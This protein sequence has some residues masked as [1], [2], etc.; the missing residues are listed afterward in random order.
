LAWGFKLD[1][2][3][4][5]VLMNRIR[6]IS[7][8][9]DAKVIHMGDDSSVLYIKKNLISAESLP[10]MHSFV[11]QNGLFLLE[12]DTH[13]LIST[14]PLSGYSLSRGNLGKISL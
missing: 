10:L 2:T 12:K 13:F 7:N 3:N 9:L 5:V 6:V 1:L 8:L 11:M 4:A 14:H